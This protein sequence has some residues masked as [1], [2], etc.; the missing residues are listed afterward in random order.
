MA[1]KRTLKRLVHLLELEEEQCKTA[2]ET[3]MR[4]L[5]QIESA[6]VAAE[7]RERAGRALV[8]SS[9]LRNEIEDRLAGLE[10]SR[11][12]LRAQT[13][14]LLRRQKTAEIAEEKRALYLAKRIER[15]QVQTL[16]DAAGAREALENRRSTQAALDE[17]YLTRGRQQNEK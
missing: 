2:L 15:R 3:A 6:L 16:V 8:F 1:V 4:Q 7:V 5:R 11:A 17:W 10:Q 9:A 14:L 13:H 12:A